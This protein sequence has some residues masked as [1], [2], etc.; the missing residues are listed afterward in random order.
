MP[1]HLRDPSHTEL[2]GDRLSGT[3]ARDASAHGWRL[4][5]S[6]RAD[7]K[8]ESERRALVWAATTS[9]DGTAMPSDAKLKRTQANSDYIASPP[10]SDFSLA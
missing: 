1:V 9:N 7:T 4:Y 6:G 8:R 5:H 10:F 2:L 3:R